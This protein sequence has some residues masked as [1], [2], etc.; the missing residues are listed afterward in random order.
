MGYYKHLFFDDRYLFFRE[1]VKRSYGKPE[2]IKDA[3]YCDE[4]ALTT[5]PGIWVF[6]TADNKYRMLYEGRSLGE[7]PRYSLLCATS[8]DGIHFKPENL[9]EKTNVENRVFEN[10]VM[11]LKGEVACIYEDKIALPEERYKLLFTHVNHDTLMGE[12]TLY[13]SRDLL[14]WKE[15]EGVKWSEDGEPITSV[16]YN[17]KKGCHTILK[18]PANGARVVGY[19]ETKDWKNFTQYTLCMQQDSLDGPLEEIYGMPSFSYD[20]WFIGFPHIYGGFGNLMEAKFYS[21][22]IKTQLAYSY[23][24]ANWYRSLRE[25]FVSEVQ[26]DKTAQADYNVPMVW[27]TTARKEDDAIYLHS[28]ASLLE[29][30]PAFREKGL[31]GRIFTYKLR[32]DGFIKLETEDKSKE[33]IVGTRENA[34]HGGEVSINIKAKKATVAV[35]Q[36]GKMEHEGMN[37]YGKCN[38]I[39]GYS[40]E[41]CIPLEGDNCNWIP[42][43]KSGKRIS[44]LKDKVLVFQIKFTDGELYS[45]SGDMTPLFN[46]E[47]EAYRQFK[48]LPTYF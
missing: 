31:N 12:G 39:E 14:D 18:R 20:G 7:E 37:L 48:R 34:W 44:D 46:V 35:Y 47:G 25:P 28:G 2:L 45:I 24:G 32:K 3:I 13:V 36:A 11:I 5:W 19:V 10:E 1:N 9:T 29:H 38:V 43:F 26:S 22:T 40:H 27:L 30:G 17:H 4:K 23:N 16:F 15:V 21:G 8:E 42:E 41:D 6:K 33:S